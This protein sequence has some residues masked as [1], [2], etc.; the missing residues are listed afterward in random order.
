MIFTCCSSRATCASREC[1]REWSFAFSS[2]AAALRASGAGT[3]GELRGVVVAGASARKAED[4]S[5]GGTGPGSGMRGEGFGAKGLDALADEGGKDSVLWVCEFFAF[6]PLP[7]PSTSRGD[8]VVVAVSAAALSRRGSIS[9]SLVA[10]NEVVDGAGGREGSSTRSVVLSNRL[11]AILMV[12]SSSGLGESS[13]S[14]PSGVDRKAGAEARRE[15]GG[16]SF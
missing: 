15:E 2:A 10:R 1:T 11:W 12:V 9:A 6:L 4:V 14:M 5:M 7:P 3:G 8:G 13:T 16:R